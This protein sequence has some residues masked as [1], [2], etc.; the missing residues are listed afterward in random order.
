MKSING[1][2]FE[3]GHKCLANSHLAQEKINTF[4]IFQ[5]SLVTLKMGHD[6]VLV[7][8]PLQNSQTFHKLSRFFSLKIQ[9][10][11]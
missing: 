9:I 3:M 10:Q 7:D 1:T 8:F 5:N 6:R 11:T 4:N 2:R